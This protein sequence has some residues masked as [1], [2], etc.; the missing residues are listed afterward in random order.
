MPERVSPAAQQVKSAGE[1]FSR[2]FS[3]LHFR[4]FD[5]FSAKNVPVV[6]FLRV[7]I[8]QFLPSQG[9]WNWV[10][11]TSVPSP[12]ALYGRGRFA[13]FP[14]KKLKLPRF[15]RFWSQQKKSHL[16]HHQ[17]VTQVLGLGQVSEGGGLTP[18]WATKE[19]KYKGE[20]A[21]VKIFSVTFGHFTRVFQKARFA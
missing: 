9:P 7:F 20:P 12:A 6:L 8:V 1:P 15:L 21:P 10:P 17:R 16:I 2:F 13:A 11:C 4:V 3:F 18:P 14:S 5:F 19:K